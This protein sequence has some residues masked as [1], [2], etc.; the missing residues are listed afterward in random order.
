MNKQRAYIMHSWFSEE[1]VAYM[2][3]GFK[4]LK[5]NKSLDWDNSFKPL[6]G[7]FEGINVTENPE[8][9]DKFDWQI[10][11][12][13]N[14]LQDMVASDIGI[15]LFLPSIPDIGIGYELGFLYGIH[16]PTVVVVPDDAVETPIN[17]MPAIGVTTIIKMS[18]LET[19]NF[20]HIIFKPYK[21]KIY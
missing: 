19:Y 6:D 8:V 11:T 1:E 14:D 18:E 20:N 9:M 7:Q 16:K 17:L 21:G 5:N 4:H 12:F 10:G 2:D 13:T 3:E 15:A